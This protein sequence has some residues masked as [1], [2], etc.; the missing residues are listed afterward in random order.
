MPQSSGSS[1]SPI[2]RRSAMTF[3][4]RE[5]SLKPA[6]TVVRL[7]LSARSFFIGTAVSAG[8]VQW[9]FLYGVQSIV[10]GGL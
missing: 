4:T 3:S 6:G 7:W 5:C 1:P 9:R 10:N 8:S 2:A